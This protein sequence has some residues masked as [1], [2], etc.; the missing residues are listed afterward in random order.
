MKILVAVC[1]SVAL[2]AGCSDK[3]TVKDGQ[4]CHL[5]KEGWKACG[6]KSVCLNQ[7][8]QDKVKPR[9]IKPTGDKAEPEMDC[10][11]KTCFA[12]GVCFAKVKLGGACGN[13]DMCLNGNKC[14]NADKPA[15]GQP[16]GPAWTC[17]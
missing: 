13:D 2:V 16:A 5:S 1:F 9:G 15:P 8:S 12:K 10:K 17:Q 14:K 7:K 6:E 3:E 4:S 11:D